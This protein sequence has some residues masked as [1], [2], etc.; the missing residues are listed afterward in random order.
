MMKS[1]H[2]EAML[3]FESPVGMI[4]VYVDNEVFVLYCHCWKLCALN[5]QELDF[6]TIAK[7]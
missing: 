5:F 6:T 7:Y 2:S 4:S 3:Q 1:A